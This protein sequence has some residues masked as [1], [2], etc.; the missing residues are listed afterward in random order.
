MALPRLR[1]HLVRGARG[2]ESIAGGPLW[3]HSS[4]SRTPIQAP[5]IALPPKHPCSPVQSLTTSPYPFSPFIRPFVSCPHPPSLLFFY[6]SSLHRHRPP[7]LGHLEPFAAATLAET[8]LVCSPCPSFPLPSRGIFW[9]DNHGSGVPWADLAFPTLFFPSCLGS[10]LDRDA[11]PLRDID[12][13]VDHAPRTP[14]VTTCERSPPN[15]PRTDRPSLGLDIPRI[16]STPES[17]ALC[18]APV[19]RRLQRGPGA[20]GGG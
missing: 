9:T 2:V 7:S 14:S 4:A 16:E 3:C 17:H 18:L 6:P 1:R 20:L 19:E 8:S 5:V 12:R 15:S 13:R 11:R 10:C